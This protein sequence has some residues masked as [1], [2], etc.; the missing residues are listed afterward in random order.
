[1]VNGENVIEFVPRLKSRKNPDISKASTAAT[2]T[3]VLLANPFVPRVQNIDAAVIVPVPAMTGRGVM[4]MVE[5]LV[6]APILA[7]VTTA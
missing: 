5:P 2:V 3:T 6:S 7:A 1:M 4:A